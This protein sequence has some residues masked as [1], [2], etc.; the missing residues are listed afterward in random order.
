MTDDDYARYERECKEIR[1]E[2]AKLL[3]DFADWLAAKGLSEGTGGKHCDNMGFYLDHFLLYEDA[4]PAEKGA[5]EV[6]MFL[7]HWFIRKAL[8]S[9]PASIKS[10]AASLKKFYTFMREKGKVTQE[11]L[12][13]LKM[14]IKEQMPEWLATVTRYDDPAIDDPREIWGL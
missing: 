5:S 7:G 6:G 4:V 10:N 12:D 3:D 13:F 9:S 2:N 8:W 14:E 1:R 11:D